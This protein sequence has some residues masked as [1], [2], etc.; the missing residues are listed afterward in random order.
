MKPALTFLFMIL[1]SVS[2]RLY[3]QDFWEL[4]PF[5]KNHNISR[6][7]IGSEG[8]IFVG[9]VTGNQD[10]GLFR[11]TDSGQNWEKILNTENF[12]IYTFSINAMGHI[13]VSTGGFY[14]LR[15][16]FNNG[17]TWDTIPI[18]IN[19]GIAK[20]EFLGQDTILMGT[21]Q[22]NGA[23]LLSTSDLGVNWDTLF[24]TENHTSE[25]IH[26]IAIAPNG[27][28]YISLNCYFPD[29]GGVYKSI[30]GGA[31]WELLGLLNHQVKEVEVNEQ[32]DLF[33]GVY[34]NFLEGG[35]GIYA[36]YH[37]SPQI[38]ECLWG[39]NINGLSINSAG[40]IFASCGMP[41]GVV[42]SIDNG[43]N[44]NFINSGLPVGPVGELEKDSSDFIYA[45]SEAPTHYIF[46]TTEPTVGVKEI[47]RFAIR[48]NIQIA[49]NPVS[50]ILLLKLPKSFLQLESF[51]IKILDI[52]GGLIIKYKSDNKS[53][54]GQV[55]VSNLAPG[56]YVLEI[57]SLF[58]RY[59]QLFLKL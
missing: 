36:I 14:P 55:D 54:H 16:S 56:I 2:P 8:E 33:I 21:S 40:H 59:S 50:N 15:A 57:S 28:I 44:F 58:N 29:M 38:V 24:L 23:I 32:G 46:K 48:R 4:L 45:L 10:N 51:Q 7:K 25:Y 53:T 5:H 13:F 42:R 19:S 34:S 20:I 9:T 1:L 22:S 3:A 47:S 12:Q 27:D 11:S 35:G 26:D 49:P 18:P 6:I 43:F 37:D 30:D 52:Y 41:S 17:I 39:P 31:T